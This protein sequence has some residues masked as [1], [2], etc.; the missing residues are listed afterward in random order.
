[1]F[2][3]NS[4]GIGIRQ[5]QSKT[6]TKIRGAQ[7]N[8]KQCAATATRIWRDESF[9]QQQQGRRTSKSVPSMG[10]NH[11]ILE[12]VADKIRLQGSGNGARS[13]CIDGRLW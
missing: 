11:M 6:T 9:K 8:V 4:N 5:K 12:Y 3:N 10:Q 13:V 1:M 7:Y 2:Q